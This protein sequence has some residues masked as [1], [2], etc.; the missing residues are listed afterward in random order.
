MNKDLVIIKNFCSTNDLYLL[1]DLSQV[2]LSILIKYSYIALQ[3]GNTYLANLILKQFENVKYIIGNIGEVKNIKLTE[4]I[5]VVNACNDRLENGGGVTG[6]L[7]K[8][9]SIKKWNKLMK[10]AK[11]IDETLVNLPLN[12]SDVVYTLTDGQLK[13]DNVKYIIH[14]LGPILSDDKTQLH[15]IRNTIIN[16]LNMSNHLNVKTLILPAIS[17]GIYAGSD[18]IGIQVRKLI[19]ETINTY[20]YKLPDIYLISY[21][22]KD[23]L[24]WFKNNIKININRFLSAQNE[25]KFGSTYNQ[26]I[27]ELLSGNKKSHFI[28]YIFPQLDGLIQNP[29]EINKM[30]SI[31]DIKEVKEYLSNKILRQRL[32]E[33]HQAILNNI[34]KGKTIKDILGSDDNKYISS[35][36]LFYIIEDDVELHELLDT[37]RNL[38][39]IKL[40]KKTIKLLS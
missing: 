9:I 14:G 29:S 33:S 17:G 7:V 18:E 4:P 23:N 8:S 24:L 3:N 31:S 26:A 10:T 21:S 37:I 27:K 30:F 32:I 40:D 11:Y 35:L 5:A 28:W 16:I 1:N 2:A 19:L 6:A 13:K 12:V 36:T 25:G 20:K 34:K 22:K 38:R 39:N 15:L